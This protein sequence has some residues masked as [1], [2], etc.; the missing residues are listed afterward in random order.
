M[1][2][3]TLDE[4]VRKAKLGVLTGKVN[5]AQLTAGCDERGMRRCEGGSLALQYDQREVVV[6]GRIALEG[7]A[8]G[9]QP[10]AEVRRSGGARAL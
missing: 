2:L 7:V 8:G 3:L 10:L 1:V 6:S 5:E 4:A 9:N